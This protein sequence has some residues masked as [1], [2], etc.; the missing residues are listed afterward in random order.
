MSFW[1][2]LV[3]S[4]LSLNA[5]ANPVE[6]APGVYLLRGEFVPGR[7]PDGNSVVFTAPRGLI[8]VDTGRHVAHTRA[9]LDFA[10][11]KRRPVAAVINTHWHLDHTGGNVLLRREVPK[12]RI[13]A[14]AAIDEAL[15]T[16]LASYAT[17]LRDALP[18]TSGSEQQ[19][20][21][22]ELGLIE[23]GQLSP[24]EVIARS[25]SRKIAGRALRINLETS[26]ATK[27]DL[28]IVDAKSSTLVAGDLVTLP[29]PFLDT[30]DPKGWQDAL[31]RIAETKFDRLV[32]GHGPV[33]T[34]AEFER[35]ACAYRNLLACAASTRK[36]CAS[37]WFA[38]VGTLVAETDR[39]FATRVM[40]YYLDAALRKK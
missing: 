14:S 22:T 34:R 10:T 31:D 4:V 2:C 7:Q 39:D 6:I 8:L 35:Y 18:T 1:R 27:G 21:R 20:H 29:V 11:A 33:M 16:F 26:A 3:F 19:S 37:G 28:W 17:Q 23:S 13:Y 36:D 40:S 32:P 38:D 5:A 25:G 24:D 9:L 15:K 30:A 12:V